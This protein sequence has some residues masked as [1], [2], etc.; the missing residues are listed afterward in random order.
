[1]QIH[2]LPFTQL[3]ILIEH[4]ITL[5]RYCTSSGFPS[6]SV[7]KN[8]PASVGDAGDTGSKPGKGRSP[9]AGNGT[10]SSVLL[11]PFFLSF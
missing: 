11:S 7:L 8:Q 2:Q 1:M 4:P 10:H 5:V 6:G 9:G 3:K